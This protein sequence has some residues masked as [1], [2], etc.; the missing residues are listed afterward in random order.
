MNERSKEAVNP[1]ETEGYNLELHNGDQEEQLTV[2]PNGVMFGSLR[3]ATTQYPEIFRSTILVEE[4]SGD[5][6]FILIPSGV[7]LD[8]PIFITDNYHHCEDKEVVGST[9]VVM[10]DADSSLEI[11]Y[12]LAASSDRLCKARKRIRFFLGENSRYTQYEYLDNPENVEV[13][14]DTIVYQMNNAYSELTVVKTGAGYAEMNYTGDLKWPGSETRCSMLYMLGGDEKTDV[15]VSIHHNVPDCRSDVLV[16]GIAAGNSSGSFTGMVYV[17]QDAQRTEAY[18]QSRNL[19]LSETARIQ[20]SPQLEI[21]ADDVKCS[22]GATV[23]QQDGDE[24]YYMRQRGLSEAQARE[25]QL[26]G[27]VDDIVM[28]IPEGS[29]R[30]RVEAGV[31]GKIKNFRE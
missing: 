20:T 29:Y 6:V 27:F 23:G 3:A 24:V 13:Y 28:R 15:N 5:G 10:L 31:R 21:Y 18:Q 19:L 25:L 30:D 9:N 14:S 8:K 11:Y 17:A 2:L 22:H 12:R 16:K 7:K 26:A 4:F 1:V